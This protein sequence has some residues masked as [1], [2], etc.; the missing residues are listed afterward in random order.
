MLAPTPRR[1]AT[2]TGFSIPREL[3]T[4][5]GPGI[6]GISVLPKQHLQHGGATVTGALNNLSG[7][8]TW[9]QNVSLWS[10]D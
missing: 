9:I 1:S 2:A 5:N 3:L 8:N 10:G 6:E 4:L 7:N